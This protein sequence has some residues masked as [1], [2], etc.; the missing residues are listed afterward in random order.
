[1]LNLVCRDTS[2]RQKVMESVREVFPRVYS[3]SIE[4]EVND[5]LFCLRE[6]GKSKDTGVPEEL[7][8]AAKS[9]QG[10]IR[11][12]SQGGPGS[13]H[14]DIAAMLEDLRIA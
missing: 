7:K 4:G 9:L 12:H 2:L 3:R 1:M 8:K 5:V 10:A 6:A 14:I 13:P 11:A